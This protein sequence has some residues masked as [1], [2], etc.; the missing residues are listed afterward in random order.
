MM[1]S[2]SSFF[3]IEISLNFGITL[4]LHFNTKLSWNNIQK[5]L[6]IKYPKRTQLFSKNLKYNVQKKNY[7]TNYSTWSHFCD[8]MH[9]ECIKLLLM[10]SKNTYNY[11]FCLLI[12]CK[13]TLYEIAFENVFGIV[14]CW[15]RNRGQTI[16]FEILRKGHE[17]PLNEFDQL[18]FECLHAQCQMHFQRPL[19]T[20][21]IY[22]GV[23]Q[24]IH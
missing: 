16:S 8:N 11:F 15:A 1:Y 18:L 23:I 6:K 2:S 5:T 10:L 9:L 21:A 7:P 4:L 19:Y 24:Y 14:C 12:Q 17:R 20:M 3:Y 22:T 13:S